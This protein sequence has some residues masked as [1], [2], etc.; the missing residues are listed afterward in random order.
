MGRRFFG[1]LAWEALVLHAAT[2]WQV[3]TKLYLRVDRPGLSPARICPHIG[4][5]DRIGV[6]YEILL[7]VGPTRHSPLLGVRIHART[8][9]GLLCY[10]RHII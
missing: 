6:S 4:A 10:D 2:R 1:D 9:R 5:Y 3:R 7:R 8:G